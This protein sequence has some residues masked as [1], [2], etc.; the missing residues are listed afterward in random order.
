M[1]SSTKQLPAA[2][3]HAFCSTCPPAEDVTALLAKL[4]FRLVFQMDAQNDLK[5][6]VYL[7][8]LPAQYHY[9]DAYGTEV[10]FLAGRDTA[11]EGEA[12]PLH[13]SRFW[14]Y[15]GAH[16]QAHQL[17]LSTLTL[18]YLLAWHDPSERATHQ[19]EVA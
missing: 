7:P 10:L 13:A 1:P 2:E 12:F 18:T 3:L 14:L 6:V 19:E 9:R 17:T 11:L 5:S 8:A 15:T 4:G 16:V